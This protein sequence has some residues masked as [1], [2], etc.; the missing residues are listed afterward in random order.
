MAITVKIDY[1]SSLKHNFRRD[2][3]GAVKYYLELHT[4]SNEEEK[5]SER[6]YH[7][8]LGFILYPQALNPFL[9]IMETLGE[10]KHIV[11]IPAFDNDINEKINEPAYLILKLPLENRMVDSINI[12]TI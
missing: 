2:V 12:Q 5:I 3:S 1:E 8:E 11:I 10:T 9:K 6:G 4:H 7:Y